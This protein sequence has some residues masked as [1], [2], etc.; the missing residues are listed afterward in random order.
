MIAMT[1]KAGYIQRQDQETDTEVER[2]QGCLAV[3]TG[4]RIQVQAEVERLREILE[5]LLVANPL[6]DQIGPVYAAARKALGRDKP[7]YD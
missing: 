6:T 2:L 5:M 1:E 4:W 3:E 7:R